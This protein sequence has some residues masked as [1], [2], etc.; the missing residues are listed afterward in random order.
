MR[1]KNRRAPQGHLRWVSSTVIALACFSAAYYSLRIGYAEYLFRTGRTGTLER[2]AVL[3]PLQAGYQARLNRLDQAVKLNPYLASAWIELGLRAEAAGDPAKAEAALLKAAH[4]DH[5]FEPR[6][7]LANFYFRRANW[8]SFWTWIR[9]AFEMSYGDRTGLFQLC[10]RATSD[11]RMILVRA[12]PPDRAILADYVDYLGHAEQYAAAQESASRWLP[13]AVKEDLPALLRLCDLLIEKAHDAPASVGL[14]NALIEKH[15]L[16]FTPLDLNA[17]SVVTNGIFQTPPL[18]HGFDWRLLSR[19]GVRAV[20]HQGL[21]VTLDG[22]QDEQTDL[23]MQW[24]PMH[25]SVVYE[26]TIKARSDDI[27]PGSGLHSK[28][29]DGTSMTVL[30]ESEISLPI[31]ILRFEAPPHTSFGKMVL[32]YQRALGT[33]RLSGTLVLSSIAIVPLFRR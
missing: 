22:Q 14:W 23:L 32:T 28:I 21:G 24:I 3:A 8:D 5:T 9:A 25:P 26:L 17:A 7:T 19:P 29:L 12:I 1:E 15:W 31:T 11:P 6:W 2:A 13:L 27:P 33:N 4:V 20:Q 10:W 30:A 16:P 18:S